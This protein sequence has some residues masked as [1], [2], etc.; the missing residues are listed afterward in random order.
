MSKYV[1]ARN[2]IVIN[3]FTVKVNPGRYNY[4]N[5][6][7][8]FP[9][10]NSVHWRFNSSYTLKSI[11]IR[12]KFRVTRIGRRHRSRLVQITL[13]NMIFVSR[14]PIVGFN[15]VFDVFPNMY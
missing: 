2:V 13:V 4:M 5:I 14:V 10:R 7:N 12:I 6:W 9:C 15:L 1:V 3:V 8:K 11:D